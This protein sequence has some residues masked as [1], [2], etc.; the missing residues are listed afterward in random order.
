MEIWPKQASEKISVKMP[1]DWSVDPQVKLD[2]SGKQGSVFDAVEDLDADACLNNC[3]EP[4][5]LHEPTTK[6]T[7]FVCFGWDRLA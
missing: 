3:V 2:E 5:M 6:N 1:K 4:A 7:V